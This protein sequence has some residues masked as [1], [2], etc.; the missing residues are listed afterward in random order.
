MQEQGV[1]KA[2]ELHDPFVLSQILMPF[3]QKHV[4][5]AVTSCNKEEKTNVKI[6]SFPS[7][8]VAQRP[9]MHNFLGLC[10]LEMTCSVL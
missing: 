6:N 10:L 7:I 9:L 5:P 4:I 2:K 1:G 8:D 3:Q